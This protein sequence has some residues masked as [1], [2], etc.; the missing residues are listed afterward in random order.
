MKKI[1][2][3]I[4]F[5]FLVLISALILAVSVRGQIGNPTASQLNTSFWKENGPFELSPERGR[6]ALTYSMVEDKSFFFSLPLARFILPDLGYVKGRYVS[7]F[8]PAISYLG[9]PGYIIGK[10][11]GVSQ[12]GA[13]A[14][15]SLFALINMFLIQK[16]AGKLGASKVAG[17]IASLAFLFATP[18]YAYAVTLY[19][20]HVSTFLILL[21]IYILVSTVSI[22][23]LFFVWF[24]CA[25]AIPVDYT[26]LFLMLPIGIYA[27]FRFFSITSD[28]TKSYI[29]FRILSPLTLIGIV[30]PLTFFLWFNKASYGNPL[31][32]SG[33]IPSVSEIDIEGKPTKPLT[34]GTETNLEKFFN[35]ELQQKSAV[36]FFKARNLINGLYEHIFSAD[37]GIIYYTPVI[38]FG[39]AGLV[40]LYR[41]KNPYMPLLTGIILTNLLL[42][43]M[44]NDPYGGWAFGSRY[45][46]PAYAVLGVALAV[47][48]D[49]LKRYWVVLLLFLIVLTYS[50]G[51]NTVG[52]LTTSANPPKTEVLALEK[53]SGRQEKYTYERNIDYLKQNGSKSFAYN[54]WFKKYVNPVEYFWIIAGTLTGIATIATFAL[55][56]SKPKKGE[57]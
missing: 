27:A 57:Q 49:A 10:Y 8:T 17:I 11:F 46:I 18:A 12:A 22:L 44:W 53:L 52:A 3:I 4:S 26:N 45:L 7:L 32:L 23:P 51:V 55:I 54:M 24:L 56:F 28:K 1:L 21:S 43:S 33:T 50:I 29:H 9:V 19:Q 39:V 13:F 34:T 38:L 5:I 40:V 16:I 25:M 42:Y 41:K 15:I 20:H 14:V 47:G 31:Q 2:S 36:R 30:L 37:R 6:F 48:L 35:P